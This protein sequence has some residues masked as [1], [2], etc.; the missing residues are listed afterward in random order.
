M[1]AV[2]CH[3]CG[4]VHG[5]MRG[6][7]IQ[8]WNRSYNFEEANSIASRER[9]SLS[10]SYLERMFRIALITCV[11]ITNCAFPRGLSGCANH[12]AALPEEGIAITFHHHLCRG[13]RH[14]GCGEDAYAA[15]KDLCGHLLEVEIVLGHLRMTNLYTWSHS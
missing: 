2:S 6:R 5:W 13:V 9:N 14:L 8:G 12:K 4:G 10:S 7:L 15:E 11:A 3:S 1:H